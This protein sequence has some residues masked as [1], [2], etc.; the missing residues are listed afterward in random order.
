MRKPKVSSGGAKHA[1]IDLTQVINFHPASFIEGSRVVGRIFRT[2]K[3][4]SGGADGNVAGLNGSIRPLGL[5]RI[6]GEMEIQGREFIHFGAGDG[7]VLLS[8]IIGSAAKAS[9]YELPENKA[10]RTIFNAVLRSIK[11]RSDSG[12]ESSETAI[13]W[14]G[15]DIESLQSI[16]GCPSCVYSFWV[17]MPLDVQEHILRLCASSISISTF[18]VFRDRKWRHLDEGELL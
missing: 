5:V 8:A 13:H 4:I 18:A 7:R 12:V 11:N 10:H 17:G 2:F 14:I 6:L 9:G 15:R 1:R 16:P 3:R